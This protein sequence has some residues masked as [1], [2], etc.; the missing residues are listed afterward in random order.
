MD[1]VRAG[2]AGVDLV[3][4]GEIPPLASRPRRKT[5]HRRGSAAGVARRVR[6]SILG[7]S[8]DTGLRDVERSPLRPA[9][10]AAIIAATL[11][12]LAPACGGGS[13]AKKI[14]VP[15]AKPPSP[16]TWPPYPSF[17]PRS[18]WTRPREDDNPLFTVFRSAP[19][20]KPR[21]RVLK[22]PPEELVRRALARLGDRRFV[23][24]IELG[25]P[26]PATLRHVHAYYR[27]VRPPK[28]GLWAWI[29][30]PAARPS[31]RQ[32]PTPEQIRDLMIARWEADLIGGA[33]PDDFCAAGGRPLVGWTLV[34]HGVGEISD[35][36]YA[37]EQ[38]FP[39]PSPQAFRRRVALV[40][41]R[42]GFRVVSLRLLRPRQL[43]PLLVV[44]T[45]RDRKG[46]MA[47]V[48][49]IEALLNPTTR[50]GGR[51]AG[52]FE[53][54]FLEVRDRNGLFSRLSRG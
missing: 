51:I 29:S 7:H 36:A 2:S 53:G 41:R 47:D 52:T 54:F 39:N 14:T 33:L 18:C 21:P 25:P 31:V 13:P 19:S 40:G 46:F 28:D 42:Y 4:G 15:P 30:T 1:R 16:A 17:S 22:I 38:R 8:A 48:P 26:P 50:E 35:P 44:E 27:G 20:L 6:G 11:A 12:A 10:L 32:L 45:S 34:R 9:A 49:Q 3:L 23:H 43:A 37:F 24:R 5:R